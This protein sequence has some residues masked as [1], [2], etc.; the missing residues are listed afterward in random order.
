MGCEP[1]IVFLPCAIELSDPRLTFEV[2]VAANTEIDSQIESYVKEALL[3]SVREAY[4]ALRSVAVE[5]TF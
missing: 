1:I 5:I 2:Q 4:C 3:G